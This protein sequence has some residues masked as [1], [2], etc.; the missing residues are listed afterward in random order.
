MIFYKK[1]DEDCQILGK[2]KKIVASDIP[3]FFDSNGI[4]EEVSHYLIYKS[5]KD[6]DAT[7][8]VK[9]YADQL[10]TFL[11]F[12]DD[13]GKRLTWRDV[14]DRHLVEFRNIK[15]G[16]GKKAVYVAGVLQTVFS[17]YVWAEQK[18]YIRQHVAIYGEDKSYAISAKRSKKG[19][20]WPYLPEGHSKLR[21]TPTNEDLERLHA[22]TIEESEYVGVRDSLIFT[23]YERTARRMEA[24]QIKVSDVP[25]WDTIEQY[26]RENKIFYVEVLGKR[27]RVRDLEFLPET[28][29]LIRGYIETERLEAVKA[30]KKRERFYK[31]PPDLFV[32]ATTGRPLNKE[33]ISRR[34]S[35]L[36]KKAGVKGTGHRVRAKGL[37]D[38]VA[39]FDGYDDRGQPKSAQ[40]VLIRAAEKAGHSNIESLR[41][42]LA[43]SRSEGIAAKLH[44]FE[45]LRSLEIKIQ[46]RKKKLAEM[47]KSNAL[48]E[49]LTKN[50][51]FEN[52]LLKFLQ[53]YK[54][55]S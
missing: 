9:T 10:Q 20:T 49:A 47:D 25:D 4:I 26:Q 27:N 23:I 30:A 46:M 3:V 50:V 11:R 39:A 18:Q 16:E 1:T 54:D 53:D 28:M 35:G 21:P 51:D 41:P 17:F 6:T 22:T 7:T 2:F 36:M 12:L 43:L 13:N 52:E 8:S 32:G 19:W 29:E 42:Y 15:T 5:L 45:L 44:N 24:L 38:V 55:N 31:E 33:Y 14:T 40:D 48:F 34:L 37:T